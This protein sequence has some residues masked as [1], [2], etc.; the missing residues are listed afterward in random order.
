MQEFRVAVKA[1]IL[2]KDN[3]LL[4]VRRSKK[5]KIAA[6]EWEVPG[7]RLEIGESPFEGLKRETKEETAIDIEIEQPVNVRHFTNSDNVIITMIIFKCKALCKNVMFEDKELEE[8][9][10]ETI[11][12]AKEKINKH[13]LKDL[14]MLEKLV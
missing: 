4:L 1:L 2:D 9:S 10:W 5:D 7:G 11:S 6:G 14:E 8:F 3:N 13:Y 12:K